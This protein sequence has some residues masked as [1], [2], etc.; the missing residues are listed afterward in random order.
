MSVPAEAAH[1]EEMIAELARDGNNSPLQEESRE[2]AGDGDADDGEDE[3]AER[4]LGAATGSDNAEGDTDQGCEQ[5][6][7]T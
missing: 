3:D 4:A 1:R 5:E 7:S 6:G 2:E